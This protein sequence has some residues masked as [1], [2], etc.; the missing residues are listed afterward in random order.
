[1]GMDNTAMGDIGDTTS[2]ISDDDD[3]DDDDD[4]TVLTR[5]V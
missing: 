4:E 3:D 5:Q 1:M 2:I